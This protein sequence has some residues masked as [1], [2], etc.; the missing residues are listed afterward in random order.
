[1]EVSESTDGL[2]LRETLRFDPK[3]MQNL[4][5]IREEELDGEKVYHLK[6]LLASDAE[7]LLNPVPGSLAVITPIREVMVEAEFWIGVEDFLIRRTVQNVYMELSSDAGERGELSLELD[8]R[9]ADYGKSVDILAQNIKSASG[10]R[11]SGSQ[12]A[13][14]LPATATPVLVV[15]APPTAEVTASTPSPVATVAPASTST[16]EP[17]TEIDLSAGLLWSYESDGAFYPWTLM[18]DGVLYVGSA[19]DHL[20]ALV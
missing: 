3:G 8:M 4:V 19:D 2:D 13:V 15:T 7:G 11:A 14:P 5:L 17:W 16:L 18:V 9:L 6:G 20:H 10:T 12:E 1:M